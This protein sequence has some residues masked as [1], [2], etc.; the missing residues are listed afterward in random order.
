MRL[1]VRGVAGINTAQFEDSSVLFQLELCPPR[2][3][4]LLEHVSHRR[5]VNEMNPLWIPLNAPIVG[6]PK[7]QHLDL[8]PRP[9]H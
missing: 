9:K 2:G 7:D 8:T 6:V 4:T 3:I 1:A 5:E